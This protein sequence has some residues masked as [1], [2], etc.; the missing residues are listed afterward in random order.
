MHLGLVYLLYSYRRSTVE[1]IWI[2]LFHS[3]KDLSNYYDYKL[4][5]LCWDYYYFIIHTLIPIVYLR[6]NASPAFSK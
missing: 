3:Y 1:F 4:L 6:R 2:F 5:L